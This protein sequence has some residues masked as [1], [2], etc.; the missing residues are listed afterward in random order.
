[1]PLKNWF[2][3]AECEICGKP[4]RYGSHT[5]CSKKKQLAHQNDK[6]HP[7][8]APSAVYLNNRRLTGMLKSLEN[9]TEEP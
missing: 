3:Q 9:H 8:N 5:A 1:M 6:R 4:R 2:Q 7:A